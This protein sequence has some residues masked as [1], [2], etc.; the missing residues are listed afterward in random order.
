[1]PRKKVVGLRKLRA[2]RRIAQARYLERR[3]ERSNQLVEPS[4]ADIP[5]IELYVNLL[6]TA[7]TSCRSGIPPNGE[8]EIQVAESDIAKPGPAPTQLMQEDVK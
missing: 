5:S 1:M 3:R 8:Q 6:Y 7:I 4:L 2:D